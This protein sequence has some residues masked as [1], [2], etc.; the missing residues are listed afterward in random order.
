M[1][2][3]Q[4]PIRRPVCET[5]QIGETNRIDLVGEGLA[6]LDHQWM[7]KRGGEDADLALGDQEDCE[8]SITPVISLTDDCHGWKVLTSSS[9]SSGDVISHISKISMI[10]TSNNIESKSTVSYF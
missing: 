8:G 2:S 9:L 5:G 4:R 10:M 6:G 1:C 3:R 7:R